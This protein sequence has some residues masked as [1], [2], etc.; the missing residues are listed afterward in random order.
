MPVTDE[1]IRSVVQE[2]L[3]HMGNGHVSAARDGRQN[4]GVFDDVDDAVAAAAEAQKQFET[5]DLDDRR[6]AVDC[7]R[8]ICIDQAA[9]L[10]REEL[11]ETRDWPARAQDR[12]A[13]RRRPEDARRRVPAQRSL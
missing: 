8:R 2:V 5:R 12:E 4:W 3:L 13:R 7:I 1:L 10:G 6:K 9:T 11:E